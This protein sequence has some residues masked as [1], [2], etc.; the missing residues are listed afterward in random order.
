MDIK[1]ITLNHDA[2]PGEYEYKSLEKIVEKITSLCL[3]SHSGSV[4]IYGTDGIEHSFVFNQISEDVLT[5]AIRSYGGI[6]EDKPAV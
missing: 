3:G 2:I 5:Q 4:L 6:C 1:K